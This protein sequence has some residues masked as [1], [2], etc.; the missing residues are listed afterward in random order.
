M[1]LVK[2]PFFFFNGVIGRIGREDVAMSSYRL[3]GEFRKSHS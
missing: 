2:K 3:L 1:D